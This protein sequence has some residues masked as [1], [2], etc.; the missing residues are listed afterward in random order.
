[1]SMDLAEV[2]VSLDIGTL[3]II[4]I[5]VTSVVGLLLLRAWAEES[6]QAL[7]WWGVAYLIGGFSGAIWR[8]GDL[9]DRSFRQASPISFSLSLWA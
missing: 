6:I 9:T 2:S 1:M 5:C 3:F 4:A 7:A 8:F